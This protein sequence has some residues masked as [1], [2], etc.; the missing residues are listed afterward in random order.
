[1]IRGA[2]T[3]ESMMMR[4]YF[5]I[6]LSFLL[7]C[8]GLWVRSKFVSDNLRWN[9]DIGIVGADGITDPGREYEAISIAADRGTLLIDRHPRDVDVNSHLPHFEYWRVKV[10]PGI[11]NDL[12]R[13]RAI[14]TAV[15]AMEY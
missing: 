1:M 2:G 11:L 12:A 10:Q 14:V 5:I 6:A 9:S 4:L 8:M 13:V 7:L 15:F 3:T